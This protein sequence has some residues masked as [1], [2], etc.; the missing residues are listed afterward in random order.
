MINPPGTPASQLIPTDQV[1]KQV[2]DWFNSVGGTNNKTLLTSTRVPGATTRFENSL[3]A[4]YM[5]EWTAGYGLTFGGRGYARAD[6]IHR[7]WSAFYVITRTIATG[8]APDPNGGFVDSGIIE[9][10]DAGL[11]RRY[12]ALQLQGTYRIAKALNLGGNYTYSQ[13]RG[14]VE[15]EQ[16]SFA[17]VLTSF[18][19]YPEYTDFVQNHPVGY[20]GPD[21][22]NRANVWLQ[23]D[24]HTPVG[25]FNLSLLEHY[26]SALSYSA[27]GTIDVRKGASNGPANG[28]VNP[29]YVTPPTSVTYFFS[30]RG[31]FR[32]DNISATD[33]GINFYLP[34]I[35]GARPFVETDFLNVFNQQGIEDPDFVNQTV[36]TRRQTTCLQTGTST[37]C[38]A[39]NPFT[40]TPVQG[41]NWQKGPIFGQ[42]TS[43]SAYQLPRT[44]RFS[45][46]LKF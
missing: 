20:L 33:L 26:H 24:L 36:L 37:R 7:K 43:Q 18:H 22:R 19:N 3:Q 27:T 14:N 15:G 2:F 30:S 41:T 40:D 44:Y 31:A 11:S 17:T 9:N 46:G 8:K 23:Y 39:F 34:S 4:P 13:L 5:D 1:I 32:V 12:H 42:P 29:G 10:A 16:P 45:V 28:V 25:M 38:L 6:Y 21:M 35:R